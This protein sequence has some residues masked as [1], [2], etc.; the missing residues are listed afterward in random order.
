[1]DQ[2]KK[3]RLTR[4]FKEDNRTVIVPMDHGVTIGPCQ[5]IEN[6]QT[7]V[8]QRHEISE[9]RPAQL[10]LHRHG[11]WAIATGL[12]PVV[13]PAIHVFAD[14]IKTDVDGRP[15]PAMTRGY[16]PLSQSA[17]LFRNRTIGSAPALAQS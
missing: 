11:R 15:A 4:I 3:R 2:G 8:N 13:G 14:G 16:G 12:D 7:I 6:M 1:M 9:S 10:S 17:Q 5:G